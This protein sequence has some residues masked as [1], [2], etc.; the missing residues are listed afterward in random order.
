MYF[1]QTCQMLRQ[2]LA[3]IIS[4]HPS[5]IENFRAVA[6]WLLSESVN[7][8]VITVKHCSTGTL[9]LFFSQTWC[10]YKQTCTAYIHY[11]DGMPS[12]SLIPEIQKYQQDSQLY[13]ST[14]YYGFEI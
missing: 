6:N 3:S 11:C 10:I 8:H 2:P 12:C 13:T 14:R 1:L 4:K 9:L 7:N 5:S